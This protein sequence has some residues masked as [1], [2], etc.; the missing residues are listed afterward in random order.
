MPMVSIGEM[1]RIVGLS[2]PRFYELIGTAFPWPLYD[3]QTRRPF[4]DEALQQVCLEVRQRNCGIDG[5]PA[6]FYGKRANG[7]SPRGAKTKHADLI[8]AI[9][10]LGLSA[11]AAQVES[12]VKELFPDGTAQAD[13]SEVIRSVFIHLKRGCKVRG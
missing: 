13:Q 2:R 11:T 7:S 8:E 3:V 4:Y 6:L 1:A 10:G 12:A 5:R 9:K